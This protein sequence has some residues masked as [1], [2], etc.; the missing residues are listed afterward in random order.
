MMYV[1]VMSLLQKVP[2]VFKSPSASNARLSKWTSSA[3]PVK[4]TCSITGTGIL[5]S[6][7]EFLFKKSFGIYNFHST[8]F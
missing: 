5:H 3:L 4:K 8:Y 1:Y 7:I 6:F 2:G